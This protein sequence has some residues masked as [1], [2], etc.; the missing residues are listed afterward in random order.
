MWSGYKIQAVGVAQEILHYSEKSGGPLSRD[1]M[2][3][4][5]AT[6]SGN[7]PGEI[8]HGVRLGEMAR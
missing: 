7:R 8:F 3:A 6:G 4:K 5:H 2:G 1:Q